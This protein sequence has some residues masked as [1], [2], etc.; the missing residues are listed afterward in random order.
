MAFRDGFL[1]Y[2]AIGFMM[3]TLIFS[4]LGTKNQFSTVPFNYADLI[5][6]SIKWIKIV[7]NEKMGLDMALLAST[8]ALCKEKSMKLEF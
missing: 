4:E 5:Y 7:P 1:Q 3:K 8:L 6:D 2:N